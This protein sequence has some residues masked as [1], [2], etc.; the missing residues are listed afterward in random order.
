MKIKYLLSA[1]IVFV[2]TLAWAQNTEC[3]G[4]L[5]AN[6][7]ADGGTA[8]VA[9]YTYDITTDGSDV[10][11][12]YELLDA[13]VGLVGFF[14][15]LNP[16]FV[17]TF[18]LPDA[19][20]QIMTFTY[21]GFTA[22]ETFTVR[23][24]FAF[25]GGFSTGEYQTY[26][27][28][29]TCGAITLTQ[30]DLPVT[31]DDAMTDYDLFDFGGNATS[32]IVDPSDAGNMV[33]QSIR[34]A[35][36]ESFA[37]T[38]VGNVGGLA[39]PIPFDASNTGMSVRVWSPAAGV[40]VKLKVENSDASEFVESDQLTTASGAWET[41]TF[42]LANEAVNGV[43]NLGASY[44]KAVIF[45]NFGL[46]MGPEETYLWDDLQFAPGVGGISQI[47]LPIDFE[48]GTAD[49]GLVDFGGNASSFTMDP[50]DMS[51]TVVQSI[52]TAGSESFAGTTVGQPL[53]LEN[54]IPF[55][56]DN[57]QMSVRVYSAAAGVTVKLKV[58]Q[59]GNGGIFVE[60]D[61]VTT[62]SGAWE[63]LVFDFATPSNGALNLAE[64]YNLPTIF[65]NF[66]Q[67]PGTSVEEIYL[68][69]D[70]QFIGGGGFT[71]IAL[72]ITFDE[73]E[74]TV[75]LGDFGG[76]ASSIVADPED[77]GN[78]VA[79]TIRTANAVLFAGT[80]APSQT[81]TTPIPFDVDNTTLS[82]R[83]RSPFA[84]IPV[85]LKVENAAGNISSETE[86][87]NTVA[88]A[89]ETLEFDLS[90]SLTAPLDF[91]IDY[92]KVVIFF[93]FGQENSPT[94][95]TYYW[96]DVMMAADGPPACE[97]PYPEVDFA[98]LGTQ[99]LPNGNLR[100]TWDPIEGQIGCQI[101]IFVGEGPVQVS[102]IVGGATASQ[103]TAPASALTPFTTYNFRVRCGCSQNPL[104]AGA[105]T[106]FQSAFYIPP[107]ITV[108]NGIG[109]SDEVE[110][111]NDD[112]QWNNTSMTSNVV[113]TLFDMK[114]NEAWVNVAPNPAQDN[115]NLSYN[116]LS[117][118]QGLIQVFDAQGKL[119]MERVMTFQEG[120]NRVNLNMNE[121]ENGIYLV[122][123][124]KD[125][126]RESVRLLMQ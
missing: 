93:N 32:I 118:G 81:L 12:T 63:T 114:E 70:V 37:G 53:G 98:S 72:P 67:D 14:Q 43:I 28:G 5:T 33:A 82:V 92:V 89:W 107:S 56:F 97:N 73:T 84:G 6:D 99:V 15:T 66:G 94:D 96:E 87:L 36:A 50:D 7:A 123:V 110:Y 79:Q 105:Y 76:A 90:S 20:T 68:W 71:S 88:N 24:K 47:D 75:G 74:Y 2:G 86:V 102:K 41:L 55:D 126:T 11:V 106:E 1:L 100:F 108:E 104:I 23:P 125:D 13:Q 16:T 80:V 21:S 113:G 122:E 10:T 62:T 120:L 64:V 9:G 57:T 18:V 116:S 112:R 49:Y 19:G 61:V 22:G 40:I 48:D 29:E 54:A 44:T 59:V 101:N 35:N 117:E 111:V 27:V 124:I 45:F 83:V 42:D 51:N 60:S 52:R 115:V 38:T 85:R 78:M 46:T 25:A 31:F 30:V 91:G 121:L 17:E 58:E 69:D 119:A 26:T 65:F 3:S 8:F 39:N 95:D 34:T 4:L 103:F 77:A 109:Y